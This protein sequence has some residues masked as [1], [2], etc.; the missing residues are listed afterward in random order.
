[1]A[2]TILVPTDLQVGSLNAL[3]AALAESGKDG[4]NVILMH[5]VHPPDGITDLLFHSPRRALRTRIGPAFKEALA[6][7]RNHFEHRI[8]SLEL[9][10]F[11]GITQTAFDQFL[12]TKGVDEVHISGVYVMRRTERA[13]D[14]LPFIRR[15]FCSVIEHGKTLPTE[16][17]QPSLDHLQ[18]LFER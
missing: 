18:L 10:P 3:K 5:A 17:I 6:V 8:G 7:L 4:V 2:K 13:M 11:H 14:P 12:K 16:Q 9:V 15:S 1:M